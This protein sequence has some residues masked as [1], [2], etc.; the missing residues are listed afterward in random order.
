MK[1]QS[2]FLGLEVWFMAHYMNF[3]PMVGLYN[4][5]GHEHKSN[6]VV[7]RALQ[8]IWFGVGI[9]ITWPATTWKRVRKF[10]KKWIVL[11]NINGRLYKF[12]K[13]TK[14]FQKIV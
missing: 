4:I 2:K 3:C 13:Q 6:E 8:F 11:D 1:L 9:V 5:Y 10:E 7:K 14:Y 12:N